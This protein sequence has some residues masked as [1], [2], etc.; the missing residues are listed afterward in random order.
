MLTFDLYGQVYVQ[1]VLRER[2]AEEV[3][4]ALLQKEG[5]LYVC[6]GMNMAQGVALVVQEILS[7]QLSM[8]QLQAV[9][10]LAKLKVD[11]SSQ[12]QT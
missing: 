2:M 12:S 9:K 4:S 1:D 11:L 7:S 6:G 10:Y 5:H 8:T 3:L